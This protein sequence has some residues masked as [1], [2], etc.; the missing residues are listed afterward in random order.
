MATITAV[1]NGDSGLTARTSINDNDSAINTEVVAA[2]A[3]IVT[4]VDS[5]S[6]LSF[7]LVADTDFVLSNPF[8]LPIMPNLVNLMASDGT[9]ILDAYININQS[10]G[11]VTMNVGA[12]FNNAI[13]T[14]L[15]W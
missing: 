7:N 11:N 5:K 3:A 2:T 4:L 12:N 1:D 15:G 14:I 6:K 9:K 8:T 13:I 10:T